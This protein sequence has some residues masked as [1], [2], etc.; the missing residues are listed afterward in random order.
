V[1]RSALLRRLWVMCEKY[2]PD[3]IYLDMKQ[4]MICIY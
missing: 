2:I 4:V 3:G 1:P